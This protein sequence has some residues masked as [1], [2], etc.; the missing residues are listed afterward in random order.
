MQL[1]R[2]P[3]TA[4]SCGPPGGP[5][6]GHD[7]LAGVYSVTKGIAGICIAL[8][9]VNRCVLIEEL[10]R[11]VTSM[12]LRDFY[13]RENRQLL[14]A[15]FYLGLPDV[16]ESRLAPITISRQPQEHDRA[17]QAVAELPVPFAASTPTPPRRS[18]LPPL[19]RT[20]PICSASGQSGRPGRLPSEAWVP[21]LA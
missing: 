7:T 16:L 14:G 4:W 21:C 17:G 10:I 9:V 6:V 2:L 18:G 12:S 3:T 13:N 1:P 20:L 15:E 5:G 8:L 19:S 11:R